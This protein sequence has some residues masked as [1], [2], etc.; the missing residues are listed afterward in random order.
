MKKL[1]YISFLLILS[2]NINFSQEELVPL[3]YNSN[4]KTSNNINTSKEGVIHNTFI[5]LFD[6]IQLPFLDD[7]SENHFPK[8]NANVNDPNVVSETYYR[9]EIGGA[10]AP[11]GTSFMYDSTFVFQYDTVPGFGFDSI[12]LVNK[13]P[14]TDQLVEVYNI[15]IYPVTFQTVKV[16]PDFNVYDSLWNNTSVGETFYVSEVDVFQD[17]ATIYFV[18]ENPA[19]SNVYWQDV[20]VYHNY[21]YAKNIQTLGVVSFD[22]LDENGYPYDFSSPSAF[23][24]ADVLT[25][26]PINMS[27]VVLGDSVYMS[28]LVEP[29]GVGENPDANDSLILEFWS[30]LFN[31]WN[32]VWRTNGYNSDVF[33]MNLIKITDPIYFQNGFQF[34]FKNYGS[35][36]GS[37]DVWHLDYVHLD[38]LRSYEDTITKDW[39]YAEPSPSFIK[40]FTAM[41]WTHYEFAPEFNMISNHNAK[42]YNSADVTPFVNPC[43]MQLSFDNNVIETLPYII[44]T[45]NI[46]AK[47]Y[48]DMN[49]N[50]PTTFWFDTIYADTCADFKV[51]QFINNNTLSASDIPQNDTLTHIQ[52]FSN[53]YSY[54]DGTAEAAYGLVSIGVELAYRF[55]L[56]PGLS[57][58][59]RAIQMHFSPSVN[60][61][62]N[63]LFFLQIWDDFQGEPGNLIYTTDQLVPETFSPQYNVGQNGFF[64][65]ILPE[66]ILVS[67]T[68]YI[69]WKQASADRLNIGFD[70]NNNNQDKIFYKLSSSWQ[71]TTFEGSL[72]MRPVFTSGKDYVLSLNEYKSWS[73]EVN[74]YPNPSNNDL[75][76]LSNDTSIDKIQIYDL[77][78]KLLIDEHFS[79]SPNYINVSNLNNGLYILQ[80]LKQQNQTIQKK[81]SVFR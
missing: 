46:P 16:W 42:T 6:T 11:M 14:N 66:K 51:V 3:E 52:H 26:K 23:G 56:A 60:D 4:L 1:I 45:P 24:V 9:I 8:F 64:E 61:V 49:Y 21:T 69:G 55:T 54:D 12:V 58:T 59:I 43:N 35:L 27:G 40:E 13:I 19:D 78:G 57:D 53:Y 32:T 41:P 36:T 74:I 50:I 39:A 17:S 44:T 67:G 30:P 79:N 48:F 29:G 33:K 37:I 5:Y 73:P 31:Q 25:S 68:Y 2:V 65:Y 77:Q 20:E 22:G 76:I 72:M 15:D 18:S 71:N 80:L 7:F 47:S 70:M 10:P 81:F 75:Y 62:S 63:K 28:F 38:V 34:R